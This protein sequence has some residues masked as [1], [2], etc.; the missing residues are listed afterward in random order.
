[1]TGT[2]RE[3]PILYVHDDPRTLTVLHYVLGEQ[4]TVYSATTV[5]EALEVLER[6]RIA[7]LL[8]EHRMRGV[9]AGLEICA[10]AR[11]VTPHV[12][13]IV[14]TTHVEQALAVDAVNAGL[15][16]TCV[17]KPWHDPDFIELLRST[18]DLLARS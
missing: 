5:N 7:V 16:T 8:C 6:Q 9:T 3:F 4:F 10:R 17:L 2:Y 13:C 18:I 1:M 11:E 15:I 14:T 12:A